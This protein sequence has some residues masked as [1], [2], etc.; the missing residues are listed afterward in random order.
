MSNQKKPTKGGKGKKG[1][2]E[3]ETKVVKVNYDS[4]IRQYLSDCKVSFGKNSPKLTI[5]NFL[6]KKTVAFTKL[7]M[8]GH[9]MPKKIESL[10]SSFG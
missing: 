10:N 1:K 5:F 6:D 4:M 2:E 7:V 8:T 3:E 9:L